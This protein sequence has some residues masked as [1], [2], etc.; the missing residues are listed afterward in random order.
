MIAGVLD[1]IDERGLHRLVFFREFGHALV[2]G[3][4][5]LRKLLQIARLSGAINAGIISAR[6]KIV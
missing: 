6:S 5:I 3:V 2:G 1:P 4:F